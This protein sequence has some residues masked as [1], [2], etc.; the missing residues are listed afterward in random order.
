[1]INSMEVRWHKYTLGFKPMMKPLVD[2]DDVRLRHY[3]TMNSATNNFSAS[4]VFQKQ[5]TADTAYM[6][7]T[8]MP[9]DIRSLVTTFLR[10]ESD[11]FGEGHCKECKPKYM[12]GVLQDWCNQNTLSERVSSI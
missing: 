2:R 4:F 5:P 11:G 9:F 10:T 8:S 12:T 3:V 7:L 6:A 1:M